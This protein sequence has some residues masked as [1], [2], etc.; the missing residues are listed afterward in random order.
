MLQAVRFNSHRL[1]LPY[2]FRLKSRVEYINT[3]IFLLL[4]QYQ[5][6]IY[7]DSE[8]FYKNDKVFFPCLLS[9]YT[10]ILG[11]I[12]RQ[13]FPGLWLRC[14]PA[15]AWRSIYLPLVTRSYSKTMMFQP[16]A[17]IPSFFKN[18]ASFLYKKMIGIVFL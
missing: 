8:S 3:L 10:S 18:S 1:C 4:F 2:F 15:F 13:V 11:E 5:I 16:P 6:L 12:I 9:Q 7:S 17:S 14:V